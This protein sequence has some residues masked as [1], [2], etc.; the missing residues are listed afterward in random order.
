MPAIK[1]IEQASD[2]WVRRASIAGP[3]YQSGVQAPKRS[4]SEAAKAAKE[5]WK[6]GITQAATRGA[7]EKGVDKAGDGK[8]RDMAIKKGPS[9]FA[10][11]VSIAKE[12]WAKGFGPY[13]SAISAL[14]LP[15]RG[16]KGDLKNYERSKL[17]GTT[18]RS[19]KE[20]M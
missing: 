12:D 17:V 11:G 9:R 13:H 1:P 19:L 5:N 3:D 10:E 18:L 6:A 4:W 20:K 16:P 8:W 14:K 2:K 7:F 15:D